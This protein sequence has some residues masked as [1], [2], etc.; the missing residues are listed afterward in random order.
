MALLESTSLHF[1]PLDSISFYMLL[2]SHEG[3]SLKFM[4]QMAIIKKKWLHFQ[5]QYLIG[6]A[7]CIRTITV[8]EINGHQVTNGNDI[9]SL[10]DLLFVSYSVILG[11][12][13][14]GWLGYAVHGIT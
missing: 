10:S 3:L 14:S 9:P 6:H 13:A 12:K 11:D 4:Q 8:C 5:V 2:V 7:S 1:T